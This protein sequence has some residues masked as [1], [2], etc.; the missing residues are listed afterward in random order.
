MRR[1]PVEADVILGPDVF[2][3]A[4][5]ALNSPPE[6]VVRRLLGADAKGK[7]K[8]TPW[9]LRRVEG[10]FDAHPDFKKDSIETQMK[11]ILGL[12]T[13]MKETKEHPPDGWEQALVAAANLAHVKRVITDHPDLIAKEMVEGIE[14]ISTEAW[15]L[16]RRMPPPPPPPST[17]PS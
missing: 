5:V 6:E 12:V 16:E 8:T 9:V 3:N 13:V 14:F 7:T 4:S 1:S 2:V 11:L 17:K 10:M 15:L